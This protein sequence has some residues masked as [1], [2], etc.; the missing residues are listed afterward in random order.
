MS[1]GSWQTCPRLA[2]QPDR[3]CALTF[4]RSGPTS[5]PELLHADGNADQ[6]QCGDHGTDTYEAQGDAA[7]DPS[8]ARIA[9][10]GCANAQNSRD[11]SLDLRELVDKIPV[12]ADGTRKQKTESDDEHE[13]ECGHLNWPRLGGLSSRIVAPPGW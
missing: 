2:A 4:G 6:R 9:G 11:K 8:T 3:W 7:S 5:A 13:P 12:V 1:P 10:S